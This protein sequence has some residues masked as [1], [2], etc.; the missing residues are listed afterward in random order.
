MRG[1]GF[2]L[3]EVMVAT[4]ILTVSLGWYLYVLSETKRE[5]FLSF[6]RAG[7]VDGGFL[8]LLR[9]DPAKG[10]LPD[11][12]EIVPEAEGLLLLRGEREGLLWEV[13]LLPPG[14]VFGG[15]RPERGGPSSRKPAGPGR[16]FPP[17]EKSRGGAPFPLPKGAG[18][19]PA[20]VPPFGR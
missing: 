2:S 4:A 8:A 9:I 1:E 19:P 18:L 5:E 16:P 17:G 15:P 7:R 13:Y 11:D 6:E 10:H 14:G 20:G 3:L 12:F